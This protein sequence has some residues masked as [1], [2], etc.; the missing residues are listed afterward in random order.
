MVPGPEVDQL[1]SAARE[2]GA[3]LVIGVIERDGGTLYCTALFFGQIFT[4]AVLING[5]CA[6]TQYRAMAFAKTSKGQTSSVGSSETVSRA[7]FTVTPGSRVTQSVSAQSG[8]GTVVYYL[9]F[10]AA[11]GVGE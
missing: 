1:T 5:N 3:H 10:S 9:I 6:V 11:R 4:A 2:G 8:S 7:G